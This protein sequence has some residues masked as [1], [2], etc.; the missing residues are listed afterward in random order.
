[1]RRKATKF[2][3][4]AGTIF[5]LSALSPG[6][7]RALDQIIKPYE[8]VRSSGMGGVTLTTGLYDEN[9]FGNPARVTDNPTWRVTILDPMVETNSNIGNSIKAVNGG[10]SVYSKLG[11]DAGQNNHF[12]LQTTMPSVYIPPGTDGK[13]GFAFGLITS[14]QVDIDLRRS[15]SVDPT[16][17][18]DIGPALTVGRRLLEDDAL[19]VGTTAHVTYRLSTNQDFT[20]VNLISGQSLSPS[21]TGGQGG[22]IDFDLGLTYKFKHF[23]PADLN[24]SVGGALDN[25]LGGNFNNLKLPFVKNSSGNPTPANKPI[26]E[27]RRGGFGFSAERENFGILHN[28]VAALEFQDIGNNPDGSLFRTLHLGGE[29]HLSLLALRAGINQGYFTGGVGIDLKIMTLDLSTYGEEMSLNPGGL[30]DRRYA[31]KLAFQI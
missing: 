11:A 25:V 29:T 31:A 12:R 4:V 16:G 3:T 28:T 21:S 27:P 22:M 30:Q 19:S 23:H 7:A 24:F 9:Y 10:N 17:I 13:W 14:S 1:M 2:V 6:Q 15:F 26:P 20:L 8:S 5:G 18:V